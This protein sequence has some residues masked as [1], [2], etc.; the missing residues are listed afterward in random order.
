M[1]PT[2]NNASNDKQH[3]NDGADSYDAEGKPCRDN[4]INIINGEHAI[5]HAPGTGIIPFE[6]IEWKHSHVRLPSYDTGYNH[7]QQHIQ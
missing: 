7:C 3:V 1:I 4:C 5:N 6:T 2:E